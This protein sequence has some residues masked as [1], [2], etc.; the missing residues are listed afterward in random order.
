MNAN[1]ARITG[2]RRKR[3]QGGAPG[4]VLRRSRRSAPRLRRVRS[5]LTPAPPPSAPLLRASA[6][7]GATPAPSGA[8]VPPAR[9]SPPS[10]PPP[11]VGGVKQAP[12]PRH[13]HGHAPRPASPASQPTP[14]PLPARPSPRRPSPPLRSRGDLSRHSPRT[15]PEQ[16]NPNPDRTLPLPYRPFPLCLRSAPAIMSCSSSSG[17]GFYDSPLPRAV[18]LRAHPARL[19]R[20]R[21]SLTPAL[22]RPPQARIPPNRCAANTPQAWNPAPPR[23][24]LRAERPKGNLFDSRPLFPLTRPPS[25]GNQSLRFPL[26]RKAGQSQRPATPT[27]ATPPKGGKP[28]GRGVRSRRE[29]VLQDTRDELLAG[30]GKPGNR[31]RTGSPG[32]TSAQASPFRAPCLRQLPTETPRASG[33][34]THEIQGRVGSLPF[35]VGDI[36]PGRPSFRPVPPGTAGGPSAGPRALPEQRGLFSGGRLSSRPKHTPEKRRNRILGIFACASCE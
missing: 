11:P 13:G 10:L 33:T 18:I 9:P 16:T 19:R 23:C 36:R 15:P 6:R 1:R 2:H 22:R 30:P 5:F 32:G 3:P 24:R 21:S 28:H 17:V 7:G 34:T 27:P 14:P 12:R 29:Q 35:I 26:A 25:G 8:S 20:V 4:S 31:L